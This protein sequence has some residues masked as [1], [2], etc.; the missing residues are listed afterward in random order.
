LEPED[1]DQFEDEDGC[2]DPDNDRDGVLDAADSCPLEPEDRDQFEDEDGCPDPDN[3]FDGIL[4]GKDKCPKEPEDFDGFE[5]RDGCPEEGSG[6]VKLTCERIE[7][8]EAVYFDSSADTIQKRSFALLD[9]VSELLDQA[10]HI[11]RVRVEGHTDNRGKPQYNLELSKRRA[12]AVSKYLS[13]HGVQS[14]RLESEGYGLDK[15]ISD[16]STEPGR[17]ANR[18]VEFVVVEQSSQCTKKK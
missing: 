5:D 10:Q 17:A 4:D 13:E 14:T 2:A 12:A 9:Q 8:K 15:P 18:R 1:R 16:N 6:L 11:K 3:D 7:I